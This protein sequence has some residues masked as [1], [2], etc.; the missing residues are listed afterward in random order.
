MG[1]FEP[2]LEALSIHQAVLKVLADI[3]QIKLTFL[4]IAPSGILRTIIPH[5]NDVNRPPTR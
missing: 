4:D 3:S 5:S 2:H 1:L